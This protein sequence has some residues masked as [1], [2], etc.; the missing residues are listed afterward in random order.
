MVMVMVMMEGGG[1]LGNFAGG[2][3]GMVSSGVQ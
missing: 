1:F 2:V 3:E